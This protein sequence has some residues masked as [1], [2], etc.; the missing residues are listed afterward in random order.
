MSAIA[1]I[2]SFNL[3]KPIL[4]SLIHFGRGFEAI[5]SFLFLILKKTFCGLFVR[6]TDAVKLIQMIYDTFHLD[7]QVSGF[8]LTAILVF[9]LS[10]I[11]VKLGKLM[12]SVFWI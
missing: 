9:F 4:V 6:R 10:L 7:G 2:G 8:F 5:G 3:T 12:A 1:A 11:C